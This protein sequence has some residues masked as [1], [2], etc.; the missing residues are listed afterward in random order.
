MELKIIKNNEF[1]AIKDFYSQL[2][3]MMENADYLPG[4]EKG[5]YP[6]DEFL[7]DSINNHELYAVEQNGVYVAAMV[8]NHECNDGYN[9]VQWSI[10]ASK[11]EVA[12]IHA[13]GILPTHQGQGIAQFLV[14]E[15]INLS[16]QNRQK[17]IRL[18]VLG[19]NIPAQRL[20]TKMGFQYIDTIKMFYEDTGWTDFL[21]YEYVL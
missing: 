4:W 13:L 17:V 14:K 7:Q 3:D 2:I 16:V 8:I 15:A 5:I 20:Y 6:T 19:T 10:K 21:L 9:N 12:I 1:K 11:D 18:D